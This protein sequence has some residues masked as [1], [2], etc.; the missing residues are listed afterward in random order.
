M[1]IQFTPLGVGLRVSCRLLTV[2][3][4]SLVLLLA[5]C[6]SGTPVVDAPAGHGVSGSAECRLHSDC[7]DGVFCNGQEGCANG[8]CV[9]GDRPCG[10]AACDEQRNRCQT[11]SPP[12]S[13]PEEPPATGPFIPGVYTGTQ[14]CRNSVSFGG[15]PTSSVE[16]SPVSLVVEAD[17]FVQDLREGQSKTT[18]IGPFTGTQRVTSLI[19]LSNGLAIEADLTASFSCTDTCQYAGDN[20]CD[21]IAYCDVGTDCR[22][23]GRL[24]VSGPYS[25]TFR[26]SGTNGIEFVS[27][28]GLADPAGFASLFLDCTG[29]L[30]R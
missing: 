11:P 23:C 27:Q 25:F 26:R 21:E 16:S 30:T 13:T 10:D 7:D 20:K 19:A 28:G 9:A 18:T 24:I 17:G 5:G 6:G 14:S 29:T 22:D 12:P 1:S 8:T 4:V 15:V 3:I 2:G